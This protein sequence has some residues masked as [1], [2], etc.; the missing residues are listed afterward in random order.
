MHTRSSCTSRQLAEALS[1]ISNP[2]PHHRPGLRLLAWAMLKSERGQTLRQR[3]LASAPA[4]PDRQ[5]A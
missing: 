4:A 5:A 2:Q 3:R 1:V